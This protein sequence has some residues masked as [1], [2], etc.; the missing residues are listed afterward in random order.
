M[1]RF[2]VPDMTCG[3]CASTI[4]QAVKAR[5]PKAEVAVS[6]PERLVKVETGLSADAIAR[7]IEDAGYTPHA[8]V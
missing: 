5:D 6:L 2:N 4:T 1:H 7:C 8:R 3:H